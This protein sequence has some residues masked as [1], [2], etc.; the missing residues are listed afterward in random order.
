MRIRSFVLALFLLASC[1]CG[2]STP[3]SGPIGP[4]E[5][6]ESPS[7]ERAATSPCA[8]RCTGEDA[9][10]CLAHCLVEYCARGEVVCPPASCT[11][12]PAG[13]ACDSTC[14]T[15]DST[16]FELV[17]TYDDPC[18]TGSE[19]EI[20]RSLELTSETDDCGTIAHYTFNCQP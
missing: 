3:R 4:E 15:D 9:A 6:P 14:S 10:R 20:G 12:V 5:R 13:W 16:R 1:G 17:L 8:A 7:T 2:A 18:I 19:V 11:Q